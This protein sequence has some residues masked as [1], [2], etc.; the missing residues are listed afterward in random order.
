MVLRSLVIR[1]GQSFRNPSTKACFLIRSFTLPPRFEGCDGSGDRPKPLEGGTGEELPVRPSTS[2]RTEKIL[3]AADDFLADW[4]NL[5]TALSF[6]P[7]GGG[8]SRS[9][10]VDEEALKG[11]ARGAG[12]EVLA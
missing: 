1:S 3:S 9:F 4:A 5:C 6:R 12:R 7:R 8:E 11:P 10:G 2:A